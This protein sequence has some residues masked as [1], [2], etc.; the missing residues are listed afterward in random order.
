MRWKHKEKRNC[1]ED[2][3]KIKGGKK[4]EKSNDTKL[5][6]IDYLVAEEYV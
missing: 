2:D 3:I 6:G 5:D 1:E 4:G